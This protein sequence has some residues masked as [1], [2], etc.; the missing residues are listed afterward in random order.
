MLARGYI[1]QTVS[2]YDSAIFF[3]RKKTVHLQI[4]IDFHAVNANT[5][6]DII[7]L[8]HI[9]ALLDKLGKAKYFSSIDLATD[10]H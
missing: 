10:Y 7:P 8:P 9:A 6:L 1:K 5:K 3:V 4:Y 2:Q